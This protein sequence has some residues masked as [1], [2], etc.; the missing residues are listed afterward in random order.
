[1][2]DI[3]ERLAVPHVVV[4][5]DP[6][7]KSIEELQTLQTEFESSIR[8]ISSERS[9]RGF[10]SICSNVGSSGS[11]KENVFENGDVE[12]LSF[13]WCL[14]SISNFEPVACDGY[15]IRDEIE[16]AEVQQNTKKD[17]MSAKKR[18]KKC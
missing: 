13:R 10:H 3:V 16:S 14:D 18:K 9:I 1:M 7:K 8:R 12:L 4:L 5:F 17:K 11:E 2:S 6:K 15:R